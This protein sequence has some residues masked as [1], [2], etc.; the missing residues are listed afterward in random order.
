M[1]LKVKT[2][3]PVHCETVVHSN[4]H[5]KPVPGSV[6]K[7]MHCFCMFVSVSK[8]GNPLV[9]K[10]V[11]SN[12][13]FAVR[14]DAIT[15]GTVGYYHDRLYKSNRMTLYK[16]LHSRLDDLDVHWCKEANFLKITM[17]SEHYQRQHGLPEESQ[18]HWCM[19]WGERLPNRFLHT[20]GAS[21]WPNQWTNK[22][23]RTSK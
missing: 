17:S 12:Y 14:L 4:Q 1:C 5:V 23:R 18:R 11:F 6:I 13:G 20:H 21:L 16:I 9:M 7:S 10:Y 22:T 8:F 15:D 19:E 3:L 2:G